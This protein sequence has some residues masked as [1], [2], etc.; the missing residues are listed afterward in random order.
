MGGR[1]V[2]SVRLNVYIGKIRINEISTVS[3][4]NSFVGL[5]VFITNAF[6]RWKI[7]L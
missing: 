5:V 1:S 2:E 7:L 6:F 4:F 3:L